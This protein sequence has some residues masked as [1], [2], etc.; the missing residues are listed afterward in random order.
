L[1][2]TIEKLECKREM[3]GFQRITPTCLP[4]GCRNQ[5]CLQITQSAMLI[6]GGIPLNSE[7]Y[8]Y[9]PDEK[10]LIKLGSN[11]S[12]KEEFF[13][14]KAHILKGIVYILGN[15]EFNLNIYNI[16]TRRWGII[17]QKKWLN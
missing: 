1:L 14:E 12:K 13:Q 17:S 7:S 6:F 10:K 2:K 16:R 15:S 11:L 8:W 5:G 4:K 9:Y 3:K